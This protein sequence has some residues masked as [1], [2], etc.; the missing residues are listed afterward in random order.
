MTVELRGHHLLCMLT[1]V[2]KGYNPAF[3]ANYVR[4]V[5]RLNTGEDIRLVAGPDD[6]CQCLI[7][8]EDEP[9]C[10]NDSVNERDAS[11]IEQ[12][13]KV[14]GRAL[15]MGEAFSLSGPEIAKLRAAYQ[16]GRMQ[17]ACGGCEWQETC[18]TIARRG[19]PGACLQ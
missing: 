16:E 11:A 17:Q 18:R 15:P 1:F 19:F 6:I 12:V 8:T 13:Q 5:E 2:G 14:L 10:F 9:H 7:A 4:I 3:T